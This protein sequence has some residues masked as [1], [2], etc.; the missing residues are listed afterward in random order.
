MSKAKLMELLSSNKGQKLTAELIDTIVSSVSS[1]G[2]SEPK[3]LSDS[4]GTIVAIKCFA[5]K[6]WVPVTFEEATLYAPSKSRASGFADGCVTGTRAWTKRNKKYNDMYKDVIGL[7]FD[8]KISAAEAKTKR[9]EA[10][11]IKAAPLVPDV[12]H[13]INLERAEEYANSGSTKGM[14]VPQTWPELREI[15]RNWLIK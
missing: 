15:A 4:S 5:F 14:I 1:K 13:F 2:P 11:A 12:P 10:E 6:V 9:A 7:L 8:N 3:T